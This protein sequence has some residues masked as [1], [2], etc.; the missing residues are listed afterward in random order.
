MMEDAVRRGGGVNG[1]VSGGRR[2]VDLEMCCCKLKQMEAAAAEGSTVCSVVEEAMRGLV[3]EQK[4]RGE[5]IMGEEELKNAWDVA[6]EL[7][8]KC[9]VVNSPSKCRF[10]SRFTSYWL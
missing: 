2:E 8:G 5:V 7:P 9:G 10:N 4:R 1:G 6:E 3:A